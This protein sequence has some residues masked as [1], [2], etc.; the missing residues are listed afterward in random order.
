MWTYAASG[1]TFHVDGCG[2][3]SVHLHGV[4]TPPGAYF[5]ASARARPDQK[6]TSTTSIVFLSPIRLSGTA[7]NCPTAPPC[8]K[9]TRYDGG[10]ASAER[11]FAS[12][13]SIIA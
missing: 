8:M 4:P 6:P 3:V 7:E 5:S 12:V 11:S 10:I 9:R 1:L 2:I 13:A